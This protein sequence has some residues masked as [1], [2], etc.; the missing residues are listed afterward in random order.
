MK[1]RILSVNTH[2]ISGRLIADATYSDGGNAMFSI[3]HNQG[4]DKP[5]LIKNFVMYAERNHKAV[6]IPAGLLTKGTAVKVE[7]YEQAVRRISKD[8]KEK[9]YVNCVAWKVS[10]AD[11][12]QVADDDADSEGADTQE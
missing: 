11:T 9:T 10:P 8:G 12:E 7:Y 4:K 5:A 1:T 3:L 6:Q 2:I